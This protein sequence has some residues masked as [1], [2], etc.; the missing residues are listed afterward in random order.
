MSD[1]RVA[2]VDLGEGRHAREAH[3]IAVGLGALA[4]AIEYDKYDTTHTA[5]GDQSTI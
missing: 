5:H 2:A 3:S 4:E 1:V